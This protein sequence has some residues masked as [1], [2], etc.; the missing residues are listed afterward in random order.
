[1]AL[2]RKGIARI[3]YVHI[4]LADRRLEQSRS[5]YGNQVGLLESAVE[6]NRVYFRCWHE[7]LHH[8]L[9]IDE[10]PENQLV[11]IGF[12][13]QDK[14]DLTSFTRH[15]KKRKLA[16]QSHPAGKP[17][18]GIGRSISFTIPGGQR[19]RLFENMDQIG[20][21]TGFDSPDWVVPRELSATPAPLF[22]NH[23]GITVPNPEKTIKFLTQILGFVVSEKIV[24]D[25]GKKV[26]S[27]L[28][29]RMSKD[30]GGQELA[31]YQGP[32]GRLH[33]I[34]FS[35]EDAGDILLDGQYLARDRVPIDQYG[36]TRQSYG[37]TFSLHFFDPFGVRLELCSGG[38]ITEAH[39]EFEP[40]VWNE[41]NLAKALS[42]YD[43]DLNENFLAPS[44]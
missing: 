4:A 20:Y 24:S 12:Q 11:E 17:I 26:L 32:E 18:K 2:R 3:G 9:I 23:A 25:D 35:K 28:L 29:F 1:M 13:V 40:V 22:L 6:P 42:W 34:A 31:V 41:S 5:F 7:S 36:P 16:V 21:A 15:L 39:P 27:A 19:L 43:R 14:E 30:V 10:R 44:I 38:R 8:S 33:H 37:K